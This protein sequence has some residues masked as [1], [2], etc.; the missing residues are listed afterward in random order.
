MHERDQAHEL[1]LVTWQALATVRRE[2]ITTNLVIA[3]SH[4]LIAWRV[5]PEAGLAFLDAFRGG[6]GRHVVWVDD[7]LV[8]A[9]TERWL[10]RYRDRAFSLTDAASF[11]VMARE[12]VGEAFAFDLDFERAGFRCLTA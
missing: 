6:T 4:G 2:V 3:E 8:Q 7:E 5:G 1:A 12:G 11:E 10:R 9:A